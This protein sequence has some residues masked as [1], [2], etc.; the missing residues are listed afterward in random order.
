MA[1]NRAGSLRLS[2]TTLDTAYYT[3]LN[4]KA[5]IV[6]HQKVVS[7]ESIIIIIIIIISQ[8]MSRP[9]AEEKQL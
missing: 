2:S 6:A 4:L 1:A 7:S 9:M 5:K 8:G 3:P